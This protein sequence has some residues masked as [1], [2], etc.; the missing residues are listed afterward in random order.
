MQ[1][2]Q[3]SVPTVEPVTL[4]EV[5]AHLRLDAGSFE[6]APAAFTAALA[7]L[8]AGNVDNGAHSWLATFVTAAG[9]TLFRSICEFIKMISHLGI[10]FKLECL[11]EDG[12]SF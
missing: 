2:V 4:A 3:T 8:G 7:G 1:L 5:A 11:R 10:L 6:P 9:E 12:I